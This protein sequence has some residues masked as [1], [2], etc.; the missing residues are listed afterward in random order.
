MHA[1]KN[2]AKECKQKGFRV[3]IFKGK[4][5]VSIWISWVLLV[6]FMVSLSTFMYYFF[7]D[8]AKQSIDDVK[9]RVVDSKLCDN[10]GISVSVCLKSTSD[11]T[12]TVKNVNY[13]TIDKVSI[14]MFDVFDRPQQKSKEIKIVSG[15][16]RSFDILKDGIIKEVHVVP[17][18]Y[19][20]GKSIFC[21]NKE[22]LIENV[23]SC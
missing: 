4:R 18:V 19:K 13:I 7:S 2:K 16:S 14:D 1:K 17:V 21:S 6:A 3:S 20:D 12:V 22:S 5:G 9:S 15:T 23:E 8:F 11:L 10:V